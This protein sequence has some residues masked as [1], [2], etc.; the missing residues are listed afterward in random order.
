MTDQRVRRVD[1]ALS[2]EVLA[3]LLQPIESARGFPNFAYTSAEF[4]Q[5]E[6]DNLFAETWACVG[7]AVSVPTGGSQLPMTWLGIP[8]LLVRDEDATLRVFH[9]VCSHRGNLLVPDACS[10]TVMQC[11]YH[12]WTYA[13]DGSLRRTPQIGGTG[14]HDDPAVNRGELGLVEIPSAEWMG[15]IFINT[16]GRADEFESFIAPL[17]IRLDRLSPATEFARLE[18]AIDHGRLTLEFAGNWKLCVDNNL[19]SYHLPWVHPGLNSVS[20][21]DVHYEFADAGLFAGQ[22]T[23][24][25]RHEAVTDDVFPLLGGW[26]GRIAEYPTLFPNVFFGL[27][28][29]HFWTRIVEPVV[30]NRTLDHLQIYYLGDAASDP[31]LASSREAILR[32]WEEVFV[33][34]LRVVAGMQRG[35]SSPGYDGGV[36]APK[37]EV[38][39]HYFSQWCAAW[40]GANP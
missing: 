26:N 28:C 27:H 40:H 18:P 23:F 25:Y 29:N 36:F 22:G 34:D 7:S 9:N 38:P 12:A 1:P 8:L 37:R 10:K 33:E 32:A 13:L 19:E 39:T 35:R 14:E 20:D 2:Q 4:F 30:A 5:W 21:V 3:G 17:Q 16:S 15:L 24:D 6:A 11:S 31:K